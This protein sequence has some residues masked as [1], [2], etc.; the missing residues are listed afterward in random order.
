MYRDKQMKNRGNYT[1]KNAL[2]IELD[3]VLYFALFLC[4]ALQ[5]SKNKFKCVPNLKKNMFVHMYILPINSASELP[6]AC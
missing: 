6:G 3:E 1:R 5:C 2:L 4:K